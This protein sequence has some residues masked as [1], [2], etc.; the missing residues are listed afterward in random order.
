MPLRAAPSPPR[1]GRRRRSPTRSLTRSCCCS[2]SPV[3]R[4]TTKNRQKR[5]AEGS[6]TR[7]RQRETRHG[8]GCFLFFD[9]AA[10]LACS[11][12]SSSSMRPLVR[13]PV[14]QLPLRVRRATLQSRAG[15]LARE[16]PGDRGTEARNVRGEGAISEKTFSTSLASKNIAKTTTK[17]KKTRPLLLLLLA[18]KRRGTRRGACETKRAS[19]SQ[20]RVLRNGAERK[21]RG[22]LKKKQEPKPKK[23]K[24]RK[25]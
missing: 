15:P 9:S 13:L 6:K 2:R 18:P 16:Q 12:S 23:R 5:P 14:L 19:S 20:E 1:P 10:L 8:R 21:R 24:K 17:K 22:A 3:K 4:M 11:C 25:F 7:A